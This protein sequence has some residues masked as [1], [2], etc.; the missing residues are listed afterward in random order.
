MATIGNTSVGGSTRSFNANCKGVLIPSFP[1]NASA[2]SIFGYVSG[3]SGQRYQ[4]CIISQ[5]DYSTILAESDERTDISAAGWY[6]FTGGTLNGFSLASGTGY[7]ICVATLNASGGLFYYG[8]YTYD[9]VT[10]GSG[11]SGLSPVTLPD[12]MGND[13]TRD[14]SCYVDYTEAGGGAWGPLLGLMNNR[15]VVAQ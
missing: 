4:A 5:A 1:A 11:C 15:L 2:N 10:A 6:E 13:A 7:L 3:T 14:Y 9:G 12:A 8:T